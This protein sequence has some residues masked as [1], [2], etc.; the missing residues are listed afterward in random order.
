LNSPTDADQVR[1]AVCLRGRQLRDDI[2][3]ATLWT[4]A[5]GDLIGPDRT[6]AGRRWIFCRTPSRNADLDVP[7]CL[8]RNCE[9][10]SLNY[11][12]MACH[13]GSCVARRGCPVEQPST[14]GGSWTQLSIGSSSSSRR[15]A[16]AILRSWS[17]RKSTGCWN[18]VVPKW[19]GWF[20]TCADSNSLE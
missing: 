10:A 13:C 3:R 15:K 6:T 5:S 11:S 18:A 14:V 4:Q 7:P 12:W 8:R 19:P 20:S 17:S 1:K 2:L 16:I 9:I